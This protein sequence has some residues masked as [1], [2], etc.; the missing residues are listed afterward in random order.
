MA[1]RRDRSGGVTWD[2]LPAES[3]SDDGLDLDD[4][5]S[6]WAGPL[7]PDDPQWAKHSDDPV[8]R[9]YTA[10]CRQQ[11]ALQAWCAEHDVDVR[12]VRRG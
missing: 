7:H 4:W 3:R 8:W 12:S 10:S 6:L 1:R 11:R 2:D 5:V 9:R